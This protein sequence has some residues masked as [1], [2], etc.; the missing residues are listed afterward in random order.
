MN[1]TDPL[2]FEDALDELASKDL[3]P[4]G[5]GTADL[6][7]LAPEIRQASIFSARMTN[8]GA[9]QRFKDLV[10]Q[11][12]S[13]SGRAPGEG[14][15]I[16]TGRARMQD[17]LREEGYDSEK[18]GFA[19]EEKVPF[20]ERG[21][22]RDLSSNPRLELMLRTK[23]TQMAQTGYKVQQNTPVARRMYPCWELVHVGVLK[24]P[25]L[26]RDWP[27]RW[28]K[29]GGQFYG[30]R[31]IAPKDDPIWNE[32]G[33]TA[34]FDDALD[35]DIPP[36]AFNSKETRRAVDRATSIALGVITDDFVPKAQGVDIKGMAQASALPFSQDFLADL[37]RDLGADVEAGRIKLA[38][39]SGAG[40]IEELAAWLAHHTLALNTGTSA[41]A[42][43]GWISRRGGA[44]H[45]GKLVD[46]A[47]GSALQR[48]QSI[49][50]VS[51]AAVEKAKA[52]GH[53]IGGFHSVLETDAVRHVLGGH[54]APEGE[55]SRGQEP[56]TK[57][58]FKL[59]PAVLERPDA[60]RAGRD[61]ANPHIKTLI[62]EKK[63]NGRL[64]TVQQVRRGKRSLALK[65]MW[66]KKRQVPDDP[67]AA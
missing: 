35:T 52:A 8:A 14:S 34:N 66:K 7:E 36:Y 6:R 45:I 44:E 15:N 4:T 37:R 2:P 58:D 29:V 22:L 26:A 65:T 56:I 40:V 11:I 19:G 63:V 48:G 38:G 62:F 9:V 67:S 60:V 16:A 64:L 39:N 28:A 10:E 24:H 18:G 47:T 61:D 17:F 12:L 1:F 55:D 50:P 49:G 23:V 46:E 59:L 27:R 43:K 33:S 42:V 3:L 21:S 5:L 25:D 31:M 57:E 51:A 41:G 53:D 20:A 30:G 13:P 54:S 32:I